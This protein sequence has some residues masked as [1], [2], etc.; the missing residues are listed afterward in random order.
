MLNMALQRRGYAG[1]LLISPD[2]KAVMQQRDV[3]PAI[4]NSGKITTFGGSIG[5]GELPEEA[6]RREIKEELGLDLPAERLSL[7]GV[8]Q[9]KKELHGE[10]LACHIFI[11]R[12]IDTSKFRVQ[13]GQGYVE[14]IKDDDRSKLN[15]SVLARE[16]LDAYFA[17]K[18]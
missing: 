6:A 14:I 17:S 1:V 15:L 2:G 12:D 5:Q 13:E 7:L 10:D 16:I 8:F 11:A 4:T 3:N 9:K 18:I